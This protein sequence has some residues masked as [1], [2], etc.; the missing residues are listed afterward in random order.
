[1]DNYDVYLDYFLNKV[2]PPIQ[3][4]FPCDDQPLGVYV[5]LQHD[6][7]PVHCNASEPLAASNPLGW[8]FEIEDQPANS[9]DT[10][11]LDFGFFASIQSL[12]CQYKPASIIG[13]LLDN[14][15][16]AWEEY[17]PV[18]LDCVIITHKTCLNE[19]LAYHG[20]L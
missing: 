6:N 2:L 13:R 10:N 9:P 8:K 12:Q 4:K 19:I 17:D 11:I 15:E 7:V 20:G 5:G 16:R 1:L 14:V 3:E 18:L